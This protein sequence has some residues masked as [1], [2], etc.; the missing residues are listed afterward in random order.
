[1]SVLPAATP[2]TAPLVRPMVAKAVL[3]LLQT[4]PEELLFQVVVAP[5][6]TLAAPVMAAGLGAIVTKVVA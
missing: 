5:T 4:P 1:M 6:H 3:P 2:P